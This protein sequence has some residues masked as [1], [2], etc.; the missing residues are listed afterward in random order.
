[1]KTTSL[2]KKILLAIIVAIGFIILVALVTLFGYVLMK[3]TLAE[4]Q[5]SYPNH[6]GYITVYFIAAIFLLIGVLQVVNIFSPRKTNPS[7]E[8]KK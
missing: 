3:E 8:N 6:W 1:M 2:F 7:K 5:S 4:P